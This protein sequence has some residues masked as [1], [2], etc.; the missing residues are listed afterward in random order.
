MQPTIA[1]ALTEVNT[2]RAHHNIGPALTTLPQGSTYSRD[3]CPV[4]LAIRGWASP[5]WV[6][7]DGTDANLRPSR[8]LSAF[9]RAFDRG[10]YP[11]LVA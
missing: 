7:P 10:L 1:E 3:T 9:M 11:E 4:A 6:T 5:A 8:V 2:L